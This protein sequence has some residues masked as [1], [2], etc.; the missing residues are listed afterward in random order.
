V[1]ALGL[2]LAVAAAAAALAPAGPAMARGSFCSVK[3]HNLHFGPYHPN[4]H[5]DRYS[6]GVIQVLCPLNEPRATTVSLSTGS[7]GRYGD[8][9]M[10]DGREELHYNL[11]VDPARTIIA[12]D[13][14]NGTRTLEG[15]RTGNETAFPVYGTLPAGQSV[16]A[17]SYSD[18]V[19]VT[20]E[21]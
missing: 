21:F 16:A 13:G 17:G 20:V 1:R 10:V 19:V 2:A 9:T 11:Y 4:R 7:S 3:E 18:N 14:S 15:R 5:M 12:G 6:A 8:R